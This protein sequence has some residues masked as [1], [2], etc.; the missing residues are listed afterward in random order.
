M[1]K[2]RKKDEPYSVTEV[3]TLIESFQS[4]LSVFGERLGSACEDIAVLK[5]DVGEIK[6]RL[7]TVEDVIRI[8]LPDIYRRITT[9][10]VK[11]G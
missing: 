9:L 7:V 1:S 3:G 4:Q 6:T 8:S 2:P 5:E 10:E 11:V